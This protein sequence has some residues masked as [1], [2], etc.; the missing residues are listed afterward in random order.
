MGTW[1]LVEMQGPSYLAVRH[2]GGYE[3]H[4]N[5]DPNKAIRFWNREQADLTMMAIRQLR[6]DLFPACLPRGM[7]AVEHTWLPDR[8]HIGGTRAPE[9]EGR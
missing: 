9:P 6:G 8:G 1:W 2:C 4:W 7:C 5:D 3:F